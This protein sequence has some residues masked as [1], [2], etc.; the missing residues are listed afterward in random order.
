MSGLDIWISTKG[1]MPVLESPMALLERHVWMISQH[2]WCLVDSKGTTFASTAT[3]WCM[4][5]EID[6]G[7]SCRWKW[8]HRV[9]NL[10]NKWDKPRCREI[11]SNWHHQDYIREYIELVEC[12]A[13]MARDCCLHNC[14]DPVCLNQIHESNPCRLAAHKRPRAHTTPVPCKERRWEL[15]L[16]PTWWETG[17]WKFEFCLRMTPL[18]LDQ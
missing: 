13:V 17:Q 4:N 10:P 9:R 3:P 11:F 6:D 2:P 1:N 8:P 5:C 12:L 14:F 18:W 7:M 15:R 16:Q